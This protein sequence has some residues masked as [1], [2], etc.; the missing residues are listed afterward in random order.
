M[1]DLL[2]YN[3]VIVLGV[4]LSSLIPNIVVVLYSNLCSDLFRLLLDGEKA[5]FYL[6]RIGRSAKGPG[7]MILCNRSIFCQ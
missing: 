2:P 1:S 6:L 5:T 3:M 7:N 4:S